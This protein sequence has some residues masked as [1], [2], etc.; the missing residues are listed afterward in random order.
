MNA[1][2]LEICREC[3][4]QCVFQTVESASPLDYSSGRKVEEAKRKEGG[5]GSRFDE[6][7]LSSAPVG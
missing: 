5:Y 3:R 1:R 6:C 7:L 2:P 4:D